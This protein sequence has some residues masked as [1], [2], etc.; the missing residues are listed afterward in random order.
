MEM[1]SRLGQSH[2]AIIPAEVYREMEQ[3]VGEG[4]RDGVTGLDLRVIDEH[5]LVTSVEENSPAAELGVRPGWEITRIGEEDIAPKLHTLAAQFEDKTYKDLILAAVVSARLEGPVGDEMAVQLLD[6]EDQP[7]NLD[8]TL[9]Q[10][11]GRRVQ[12]GHLPTFYVWMDVEAIDERIGYITFSSFFDPSHVMTAFNE[13]VNSFMDMDGVIINIRGNPGGIG[14]M[15]I[16][17][18]PCTRGTTR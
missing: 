10:R 12:F 1:I 13:A 15:A 16:A 17:W 5:A 18:G 14:A 2:F 7:V 8:I 6:G 4:P 9:V 3:P 11:R